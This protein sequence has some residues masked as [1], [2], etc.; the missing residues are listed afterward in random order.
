VVLWLAVACTGTPEPVGPAPDARPVSLA[1]GD[2]AY[3]AD[4]VV[5]YPLVIDSG[6]ERA[7]REAWRALVEEGASS[8]A[9]AVAGDLLAVDPGL[10]PATVLAAQVGFARRDY[11]A[12]AAALRP[13]VEE[14]PGYGAAQ[15]LM[16]RLSEELGHLPE[17]YSAYRAASGDSDLAAE[18][19]AEI[20]PRA[21]DIL[22]HRLDEALGRGWLEEAEGLLVTLTAWDPDATVTLEATRRVATR[23]GDP[24]G[25]LA[26]VIRLGE[27]FPERRDLIERRG[28]LE[29]EVGDPASGLEIFTAL[30][31]QF[32]GD[33]TLAEKL[34]RARFRWRLNLLP[35]VAQRAAAEVELRRGSFAVLLY[36]LVSDVRYRRPERPRIATDILDHPQRE[37]IT[38]VINL[39]LMDIDDTV[40]HFSPEDPLRQGSALAALLSVL[41]ELSERPAACIGPAGPGQAW[42]TV[43]ASAVRCQLLTDPVECLPQASLSGAEAVELIRRTLKQL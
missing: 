9:L 39:G 16:G 23:R 35:E 11:A 30:V 20:L 27:R 28:E 7:L 19:A 26:A 32:P 8:Q 5:G 18:R 4:P 42:E 24:E 25:E 13:V 12:A 6:R 40:H 17:A 34:E 15:L 33:P 1:R 36:W 43:C 37:A 10:H 31:D 3:L 29:L 2:L 22:A 21:L 14:L 41:A 38:R